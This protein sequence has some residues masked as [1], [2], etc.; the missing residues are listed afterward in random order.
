MIA[1]KP[2][3]SYIIVLAAVLFLSCEK[4]QEQAQSPPSPD[5]AAAAQQSETQIPAG[6]AL[7]IQLQGDLD[8]SKLKS[9]DHFS[10]QIVEDVILNGKT[11]IPKGSSAKGRV[12]N[13][14]VAQS[15]G[16]AGVLSLVLESVSAK[17]STYNLSTNPVTLEGANLQENQPKNSDSK[18]GKAAQSAYVPKHGTLRFFLSSPVNL[19]G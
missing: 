9:G 4:K 8:S 15:Q 14:S 11:V 6:T 5:Q 3:G 19:K 2:Y 17:G 12:T 10:G 13:S 1:S 18:A 7:W 16:S